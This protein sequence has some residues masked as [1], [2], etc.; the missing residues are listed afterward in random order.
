MFATKE[1]PLVIFLD[2][3]QWADSGSLKLMQLL[4]SEA[5]TRYLL[6][7]GAYR[8]NEVFPAHPLMLTLDEIRKDSATI[9]QITL[10]P[11]DKT[12][13]NRLIADT[14]ICPTERAIP[15][16]EVIFARTKGNPFFATKFLK[17]LHSDGFISFDYTPITAGWQY[18]I[19]KLRALSWTDDVVE[20]MAIQLQKLPTNTQQALKL[21]ACV[22]NEFDLATLAIVSKKS[23]SEI[24]ADLWPALQ[25][26]LVIPIRHLRKQSKP[27][28]S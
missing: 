4:M 2:D 25:E 12:S 14:M 27:L 18:D 8:D 24:A 3:L 16:T 10:V 22:G 1:H 26:G 6:L 19:A 9:N 17:F 20:F 7:M 15:L 11:L 23:E 5:D 21:A 28:C 13:L